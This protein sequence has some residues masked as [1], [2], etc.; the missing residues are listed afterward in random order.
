MRKLAFLSVFIILLHVSVSVIWPFV[1]AA[2]AF[3]TG[4]PK[5]VAGA[6]SEAIIGMLLSSP[7]LA[8]EVFLSVWAIR[9]LKAKAP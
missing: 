5:L 6:V 2:S 8:A 7:V 1:E 3:Q 4:D 9:R